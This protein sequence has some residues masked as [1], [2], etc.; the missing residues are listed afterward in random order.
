MARS[1]DR[2]EKFRWIGPI[3]Q[4]EWT[5]YARVDDKRAPPASLEDVRG[6]LIGGAALDVITQWLVASKFKV[7]QTATDGLNPAKLVAGRFDYW[8]VSRQRGATTTALAGLTGKV[9]P[10]LTFGHSDLYVGCH[11]NT[12]DDVIRK[13]NQSL[14][15]MRADGTVDRIL[16]RYARYAPESATP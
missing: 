1:H 10:V 6:T 8:A 5:L 7:D 13:L 4:I 15:E 14:A 16:A 9:A 12:P 2:E 3:A 11:R